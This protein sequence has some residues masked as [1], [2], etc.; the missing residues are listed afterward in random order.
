MAKIR[1]FDLVL[2]PSTE[3]SKVLKELQ[4]I[5]GIGKECA[6]DLWS[7][8]MRSVG[9]LARKNPAASYDKL[10]ALTGVTQDRCMLY[11][12]RWAVYFDRKKT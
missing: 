8:G 10:N 4:V 12:F 11:T 3:K 6:F 5:P 7:I 1:I 2:E 9:D